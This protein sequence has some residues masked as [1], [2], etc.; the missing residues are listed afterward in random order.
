MEN[1]SYFTF[2]Q[3]GKTIFYCPLA[4]NFLGVLSGIAS[5]EI[6][7]IDTKGENNR[8]IF[9]DDRETNIESFV[10][11]NYIYFTPTKWDSSTY[12]PEFSSYIVRLDY[13]SSDLKQNSLY[14]YQKIEAV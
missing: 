12:S 5:N 13:T 8:H 7:S 1:V 9:T 3:D 11:K 2:S 4:N 6:Y 10:Y 14:I